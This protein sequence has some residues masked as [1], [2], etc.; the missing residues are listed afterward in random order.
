[1]KKT[2]FLDVVD[3]EDNVIGRATWE[4]MNRDRLRIRCS[5]VLVF[6][7]EGKLFVHKR[8]MSLPT[9]PGMYDVKLGGLVDSGETY[10]QAAVREMQEEAG[11]K[12]CGI[13]FLA[14][15]ITDR[16]N[17]KIYRAVYDGEMNLDPEE[18]ESGRF[19]SMDEVNRLKEEGRLSGPALK[20]LK[21]YLDLKKGGGAV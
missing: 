10:E 15:Q 3:E 19:M 7:S 18:I 1:M 12:N 11:I 9:E 17:R 21:E 14:K 13:E 20:V 16:V 8:S 4:E 2:S 6:N 5:A